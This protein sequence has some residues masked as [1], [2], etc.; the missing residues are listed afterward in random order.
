MGSG[1]LKYY[2]NDNASYYV[3]KIIFDFVYIYIYIM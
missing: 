3:I 2:F 1:N